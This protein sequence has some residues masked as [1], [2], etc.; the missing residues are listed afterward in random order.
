MTAAGF[1]A[2]CGGDATAQ[3]TPDKELSARQR[4]GHDAHVDLVDLDALDT[5]D[6]RG[7]KELRV[8]VGVGVGFAANLTQDLAGV[9]DVD[10]QRERHI[11]HR[12][13]PVP[14]QVGELD[15]LAV[16]SD[17]HLAVRGA[18]LGHPQGHVLDR[19]D[20]VARDSRYS[21]LDQVAEAVLPLRDD[22]EARQQILDQTL[23]AEA[24]CH[25]DDVRR[26][27]ESRDRHPEAGRDLH[28]GDDIR[29]DQHRPREH[30][31][32]GVSMFRGL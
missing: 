23:R 22:E 27:H 14:R 17:D 12:S 10:R 13:G 11:D 9:P 3:G 31:G 18:D 30:L 7:V 15:D 8:E 25:A 20:H 6:R 4:A 1:T 19:A 24:Q 5:H 21:D 16:R 29:D 32:Q 26:S 2:K 28:S